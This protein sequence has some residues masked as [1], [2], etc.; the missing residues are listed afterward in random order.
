MVSVLEDLFHICAIY[1]SASTFEGFGLTFL[2]ALASGKPVVCRPVGVAP[3]LVRETDNVV[4]A[5]SQEAFVAAVLKLLREGYEPEE[6]RRVAARYD[7][8]KVVD[9]VEALYIDLL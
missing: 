7:W 1:A 9:Q 5:D 3:E 4:L 8:E 6:S 2:E